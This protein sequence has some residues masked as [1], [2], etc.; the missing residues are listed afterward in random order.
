[1]MFARI[2]Q[3]LTKHQNRKSKQK[4]DHQKIRENIIKIFLDRISSQ[5]GIQNIC[6]AGREFNANIG[7]YWRPLTAI[8]SICKLAQSKIFDNH[9]GAL[10]PC[11]KLS[12][13][14]PVKKTSS[15]LAL[16]EQVQQHIT[17]LSAT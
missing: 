6:K 13:K 16:A 10:I 2:F 7:E 11:D 1:M 15:S 5:Y 4:T 3:K 12:L 8:L 17:D 14:R 9:D